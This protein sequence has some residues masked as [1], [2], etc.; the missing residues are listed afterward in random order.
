MHMFDLPL[1]LSLNTRAR[2][3][4]PL[5]EVLH[6]LVSALFRDVFVA[7]LEPNFFHFL[8]VQFVARKVV[9][10]VRAALKFVLRNVLHVFAGCPVFFVGE[11]RSCTL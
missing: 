4:P 6:L 8:L 7:L 5:D 2:I 1:N 11:T 9:K 10:V 3:R